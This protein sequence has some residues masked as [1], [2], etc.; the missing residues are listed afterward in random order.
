M[1]GRRGLMI[2]CG[3]LGGIL[4]LE[5]PVRQRELVS[6]VEAALVMRRRQYQV[7]ALKH[8]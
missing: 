7:E 6:M 5:H 8:F 2:G 3:V 1:A 4:L